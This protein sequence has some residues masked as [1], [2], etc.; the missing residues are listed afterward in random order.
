VA[1]NIFAHE[2]NGKFPM[3][4][5]TNDGGALELLP[6]GIQMMESF[7]IPES[8]SHELTTPRILICPADVRTSAVNF[9]SLTSNNI[10]Y[11]VAL[12]TSVAVP[13][14]VLAGDRN[15]KSFGQL[16]TWTNGLHEFKGN[17]LFGDAHVEQSSGNGTFALNSGGFG[18]GITSA[19]GTPPGTAP[20]SPIP[21][22]GNA[23]A[24]G[25]W[26]PS[27]NGDPTEPP[28]AARKNSDRSNATDEPLLDDDPLP[29]AN[30]ADIDPPDSPVVTF[31]RYVIG[32]GFG[33]SLLWALVLILML[34]LKKQR[35]EREDLAAMENQE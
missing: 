34:L 9:A 12:H 31:L 35:E 11:F 2:H 10:S 24:S 30:N 26:T 25:S 18:S 8:I 33:V 6:P 15:V 13:S 16:W 1:M 17:L 22:R 20:P 7:Q 5:S 29:A 3:E 4:T 28:M 14:S 32:I 23:G 19:S 27:R 21:A